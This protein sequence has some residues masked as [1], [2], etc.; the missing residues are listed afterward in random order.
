M[1]IKCTR[2]PRSSSTFARYRWSPVVFLSFLTIL[3][4]IID[5]RVS[6]MTNG[7]NRRYTAAILSWGNIVKAYFPVEEVSLASYESTVSISILVLDSFQSSQHR[8]VRILFPQGPSR[9][10]W[11]LVARA[12]KKSRR[13]QMKSSSQNI[14][15]SWPNIRDCPSNHGR[16]RRPKRALYKA[17]HNNRLDVFCPEKNKGGVHDPN[18]TQFDLQCNHG[19]HEQQ[20]DSR[21]DV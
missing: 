5:E 4:K 13:R 1:N 15:L 2:L 12:Y 14:L 7:S 10:K 8:Q 16:P 11:T 9:R 19:R 18:Q 21:T 20:S 6:F 17:R 3:V